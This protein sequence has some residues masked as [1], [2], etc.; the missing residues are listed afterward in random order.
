MI[1]IVVDPNAKDVT[2]KED[3]LKGLEEYY[4]T[5]TNF[6]YEFHYNAGEQ[7]HLKDELIEHLQ[8]ENKDLRQRLSQMLEEN[9]QLEEQLQNRI[10]KEREDGVVT[11]YQPHDNLCFNVRASRLAFILHKNLNST[12]SLTFD[13]NSKE[14]ISIKVD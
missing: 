7:G 13:A 6:E 10:R 4:R 11:D 12:L 9:I 8:I 1:E 2:V 14:L 5:G 3:Y